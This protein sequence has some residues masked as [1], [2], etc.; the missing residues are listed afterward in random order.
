MPFNERYLATAGDVIDNATLATVHGSNAR[1]QYIWQILAATAPDLVAAALSETVPPT[2]DAAL[3][4]TQVE[5]KVQGA[6]NGDCL[7]FTTTI[8]RVAIV[9]TNEIAASLKP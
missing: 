4:A 2:V 1:E 7:R 5:V 6:I 9:H 8:Q 3:R